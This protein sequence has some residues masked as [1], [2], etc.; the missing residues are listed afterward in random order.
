MRTIYKYKLPVGDEFALEMPAGAE[1]LTV[2]MQDDQPFIWALVNTDHSPQLRQFLVLG[3]GH[4][5][6]DTRICATNYVGTFQLLGGRLVFHLF[7]AR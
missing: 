6:S 5:C 3:T 1:V 4:D 2:Q 7:E